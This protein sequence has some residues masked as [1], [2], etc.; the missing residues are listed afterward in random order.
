MQQNGMTINCPNCH[1]PFQGVLEQII[2]VGRDPSG[3]TRLLSGRLNAATCPHCGYQSMLATPLIYHDASK[4][5]L[6]VYVPMELGLPPQEQNRLIGSMTNAIMNSMPPEQ[7]K[8][9]LL[10]PKTMLTLQGMVETILQADGI[11]KEVIEAQRAKMRLV[12]EFLQAD[13]STL[14]QLV[15]RHDAEIDNEFFAI[16]GASAEATLAGGRRDMAEKMLQLRE[17]LLEMTTAGRDLI[18]KASAQEAAIQSVADALNA[19]GEKASYDDLVDLSL[20]LA[21][22]S[23]DDKLQVLVGLARPALDYEF[24]QT[25]S[26]RIDQAEGEEKQFLTEVREHLLE[27]IS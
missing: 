17:L 25:L 7:R 6:L 22:E 15:E 12:E 11:T 20:Q 8:G 19:L 14:P 24:F 16:L 2:D 26:S 4:E 23:G 9:Y 13:P 10:N 27:L 3:K 21:S 1:Q 5:L 18:E